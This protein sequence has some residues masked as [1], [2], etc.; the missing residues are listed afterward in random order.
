MRPILKIGIALVVFLAVVRFMGMRAELAS[1]TTDL[2][3]D[4]CPVI[5]SE[6]PQGITTAGVVMT[7]GPASALFEIGDFLR[8]RWRQFTSQP[9]EE[10]SCLWFRRSPSKF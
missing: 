6:G 10:Q 5:T 1:V 7:Y 8:R 9:G 4:S 2:E 3:N